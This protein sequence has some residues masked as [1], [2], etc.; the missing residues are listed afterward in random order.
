MKCCT[1]CK[2]EKNLK[3]FNR[4]KNSKDG[5]QNI[6][7]ECSRERSRKY[8][9]E[10]S[11]KH[12]KAVTDNK[13]K[14]REKIQE[15]IFNYLLKHPCVKCGESNPI[16]LDFDHLRDK[17]NCI[18]NGIRN[19]WSLDRV[20]KEIEKC[21]VLCANCHRLKTAKDQ[22]WYSYRMLLKNSGSGEG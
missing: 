21:Q 13:K 9:K 3:D 4:K 18:C 6:C 11:D 19:I 17:D 22:S 5:V 20:K 12:L 1:K 8:Y 14:Y 16:V 15:F 10:N 2:V 7:K